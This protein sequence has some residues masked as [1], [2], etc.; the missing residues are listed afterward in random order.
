MLQCCVCRLS[1]VCL[2]RYVLWLNGAS[3]SKSYYWQTIGSRIW[4]IDWY[5]NEWPWP[6]FRGRLRSCEPLRRICHWISRKPLDIEAWF[7]TTTNRKW[8]MANEMF[9]WPWRHVISKGQ[10]RDTNTIRPQY[11]ENRWRC[12]LATIANYYRESAVRQY[13][14]LS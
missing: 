10:T 5:Q 14:R 8:P 6:L 12:C 13:G 11:L 4:G 1:T 2:W 3:K 9:T 7:Q